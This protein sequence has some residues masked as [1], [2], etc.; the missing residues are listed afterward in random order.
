M[1]VGRFPVCCYMFAWPG[2][3]AGS[4]ILAMMLYAVFMEC[5]LVR[6]RTLELKIRE[7]V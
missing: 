1:K 5:L 2:I 6:A 3:P 7:K 4:L